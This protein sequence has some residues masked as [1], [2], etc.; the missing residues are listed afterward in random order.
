[1]CRSARQNTGEELQEFPYGRIEARMKVPCLARAFWMFAS[2]ADVVG[3]PDFGEIDIME[4]I[5]RDADLIL[6]I[7]TPARVFRSIRVKQMEPLRLRYG[8]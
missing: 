4:Y 1:M 3:W 8:R 6:G 2:N 5:G 7:H